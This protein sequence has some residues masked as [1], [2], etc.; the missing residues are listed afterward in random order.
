MPWKKILC[1]IDFSETARQAMVEGLEL[2]K[3]SG[4]QVLLLHVL[5][6]HWLLSR[7]ELLAPPE[8][9]DRAAQG[10]RRD[11]TV[12]KRVAEEIAPGRVVTE[13]VSGHP[14]TEILRVA[15][16][17]AFDA[18]VMGTHGRRGLR[19]FVI[20]SVAD[21]VARAARCSVVVVRKRS[22]GDFDVRPD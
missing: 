10:A 1:P 7:G 5:E 21:E 15:R 4:G 9:L 14:A 20:G 6:E 13:I 11:L 19:K 2:A 17:G 3:R 16:E 8:L 18:V 12:W 22:D